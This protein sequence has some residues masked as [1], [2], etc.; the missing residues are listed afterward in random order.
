MTRALALLTG[1]GLGMGVFCFALWLDDR[2][3]PFL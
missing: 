2:W 3:N 1:M